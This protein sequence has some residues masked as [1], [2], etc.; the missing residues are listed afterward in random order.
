MPAWRRGSPASVLHRLQ[1]LDVE[2]PN[3]SLNLQ[4]VQQSGMVLHWLNGYDPRA[5]A[6]V[7]LLHAGQALGPKAAA[8]PCTP[9]K[10]STQRLRSILGHSR[11]GAAS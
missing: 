5:S 9:S 2:W 8:D 10:H 4:P 7:S 6:R 3:S 1:E 11:R